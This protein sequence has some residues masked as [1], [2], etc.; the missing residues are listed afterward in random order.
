MGRLTWSEREVLLSSEILDM[1]V[2]VV[3]PNCGVEYVEKERR[4]DTSG[5]WIQFNFP[6]SMPVDAWAKAC[7]R[8]SSALAPPSLSKGKP[9]RRADKELNDFILRR[10]GDMGGTKT[11][12]YQVIADE[13]GLLDEAV[14]KRVERL[15]NGNG[16]AA[17]EKS[18]E[19]GQTRQA[20]GTEGMDLVR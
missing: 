4:V 8:L 14:R 2:R 1:I 11:A 18:W 9:G 17:K 12:A 7:G 3:E 20:R 15:R 5:R 16:R 19:A 13:T 6:E 10:M